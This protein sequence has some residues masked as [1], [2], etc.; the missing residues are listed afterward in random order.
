M[1]WGLG[2]NGAGWPECFD[3]PFSWDLVSSSDQGACRPASRGKFVDLPGP[4]FGGPCRGGLGRLSIWPHEPATGTGRKKVVFLP[5]LSPLPGK[6]EHK[7]PWE[8][9]PRKPEPSEA[10]AS[11]C[12]LPCVHRGAGLGQVASQCWA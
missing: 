1:T 7:G 4:S 6:H 8:L 12:L 11:A 9:G 10:Q 5:A 3:S 2:G